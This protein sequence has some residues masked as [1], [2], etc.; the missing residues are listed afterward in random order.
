MAEVVGGKTKVDDSRAAFATNFRSRSVASQA[1]SMN[2][3]CSIPFPIQLGN[4]GEV[5]RYHGTRNREQN[6]YA[7]GDKAI[8]RNEPVRDNHRLDHRFDDGRRNPEFRNG[9]GLATIALKV[10]SHR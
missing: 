2:E 10:V 3:D 9:G 8:G 6:P 4:R 7:G 5:T 1:V